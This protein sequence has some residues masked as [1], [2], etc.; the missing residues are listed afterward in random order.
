MM[1]EK[2]I[3]FIRKRNYKFVK[4]LGQGACGK[5]VLLYDDMINEHFVCK[6]Y[7]PFSEMHRQELFSNFIR[8][9]KLLHQVHHPNVVR[10]FNYYLYPDKLTGY[11]LMEFVDGSD[12]EDYI[13]NSPEKTN[14]IFLQ[15]INGFCYLE[16]NNILHRDIRPKNIMVT[17]GDIVKII[18]LGF[19]KRIERPEDFDKSI[20][21]NS[22]CEPPEEFIESL[23]DFKTEIY[24]TG[25]LFEKII[26]EKGIRHFKY[27]SI[28][29]H[30]CSRD[31]NSRIQSFFDVGKEINNDMFFEIQFDE[32]E[33]NNYR[34][35]ADNLQEH[36]K[37]IENGC[38]YWNDFERIQ[39]QME[40]AYRRFM[41]EETAP[42][43]SLII[44]CFLNGPYYYAKTGFPVWIVR[45][46]LHLFK[47]SS[48]EKRR[49][50]MAN[51]HTRLDSIPRYD[52]KPRDEDDVPF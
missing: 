10:V 33:L 19:G 49:I 48:Q 11:I 46:F 40:D 51:L 9:I 42:D 18:D 2:I 45:K 31:P 15:A 37:K 26:Q 20:S 3:E 50:I 6:K 41:L 22:W 1:Q 52:A 7:S 23:Y 39:S 34:R 16:A 21:L 17:S 14:E 25:K 5:T 29:S 12:I 44:R 32:A 30:M 35:F 27:K 47:S 36:I 38:K 13:K 43:S 24:F 4:D 8:E 28:L